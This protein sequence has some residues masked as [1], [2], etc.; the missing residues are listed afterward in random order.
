MREQPIP[1]LITIPCLLHGGTE[2]QTLQLVN[3]LHGAGYHPV[4]LVLFEY[5]SVMV[6]QMGEAGAE[7]RL[8]TPS[9]LRPTGLLR[10]GIALF[11]GLRST[12]QE[13]HPRVV[14]VQYMTPA[15]LLMGV[16]KL[17]GVKSILA[18]VHT[19]AHI[20]SH[21]WIVRLISRY[22]TKSFLTV[23]RS[24][25][26]GFFGGEPALFS[27]EAF[28]R[29]RRHFTLYNGITLPPLPSPH[30]RP[31]LTLGVVSRL[32]YEKGIDILLEAMPKVLR[33][34]PTARLLIVGEGRERKRLE[35]LADALGIC[36]SIH[37]VGLQPKAKLIHYYGQMNIVIVPS[38]FEG[39]GLTAL[40][41]MSLGIPVIV[42]AVDGLQEV[43]ELGVSGVCFTPEDSASLAQAI[44]TLGVD[45]SR[46][47]RLGVAGRERVASHFS[48]ARYQEATLTL[49][50][51]LLAE[52]S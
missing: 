15:V 26:V 8:M 6:E 23:S 12:L 30:W 11:N 48:L 45:R 41:A 40:E 47:Q 27:L 42:S 9:G 38:R 24:A 51:M 14:H 49:Y 34:I 31:P 4:V 3:V 5:D 1:I 7:V 35:A 44:T 2:Y 33:E 25:E 19:P 18:T 16:L 52:G 20:Y 17:L 28:E 32:S 29:G 10:I 46:R 36:A 13:V 39:F 50:R 22:A 43:V 37:W 21:K